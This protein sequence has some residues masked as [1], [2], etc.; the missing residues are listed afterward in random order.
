[1]TLMLATRS[2]RARHLQKHD[3]WLDAMAPVLAARMGVSDNDPRPRLYCSTLLAASD[4]GIRTWF[5]GNTSGNLG[6]AMDA[7]INSLN[8]LFC[9]S[10]TPHR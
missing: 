2:L 7:A 9:E 8:E 4:A 5:S 3:E 10:G 1:M 6:D